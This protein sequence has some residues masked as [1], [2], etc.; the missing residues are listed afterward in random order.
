MRREQTIMNQSQI[1]P[2]ALRTGAFAL[3]S[4]LLLGLAVPALAHAET[5]EPNAVAHETVAAEPA[6]EPAPEAAPG[7]V[8]DTEPGTEPEAAPDPGQPLATEQAPQVA[9]L[10][11]APANA[12]AESG[13]EEADAIEPEDEKG[14]AA[15]PAPSSA[16]AAA[17]APG[18]ADF[19][20]TGIGPGQM[21]YYSDSVA[22]ALRYMASVAGPAGIEYQLQA[23]GHSTTDWATP[24]TRADL[25]FGSAGFTGT[26]R[27]VIRNVG[28][29]TADVFIDRGWDGLE[30]KQLRAY[31][32][33]NRSDLR[34]TG[35]VMPLSPG[36]TVEV[37]G[38]I[39]GASGAN[40]NFTVTTDAQ[41]RYEHTARGLAPGAYTVNVT[42]R[43]DGEV[44]RTI[45]GGR[46]I[47]AADAPQ[48]GLLI[49]PETGQVNGYYPRAVGVR[50][51]VVDDD[52]IEWIRATTNGPAYQTVQNGAL[53]PFATDGAHTLTVWAR[54]TLGNESNP[55]TLEFRIDSTDPTV[56][57][58]GVLAAGVVERG[59]QAVAEFTCDDATSGI[60][61]CLI[62]F[63]GGQ[64]QATGAV[65]D[66]S[67]V[68]N[69]S[70]AI[71]ARDLAGREHRSE[72]ALMVR[73]DVRPPTVTHTATPEPNARGWNREEVEVMLDARDEE[74]GL[75]SFVYRVNGGAWIEPPVLG[76][77]VRV[78]V[79]GDGR[80]TVQ[81]VAT[82]AMGNATPLTGRSVHIDA[83][84]P[85]VEIDP[86]L[87][88]RQIRQ[89]AAVLA[90]F[91]CSD[92]LSGLDGCV[93]STPNGQ[94]LPTGQ[95]G[96]HALTVTATDIAGN[97]ITRRVDYQVVADDGTALDAEATPDRAGN[98]GWWNGPVSVLLNP[99]P[100]T[101]AV[102]VAWTMIGAQTGSGVTD[103]GEDVTVTVAGLTIISYSP[104]DDY[105]RRGDARTIE[106]RIDQTTPAASAI[107]DP[108]PNARGWLRRDATLLIES[109]DRESGLD[110]LEYRLGDG[111]WVSLSS[112]PAQVPLT[113]EGVYAIE[114]RAFDVAGN[115][116]SVRSHAV[117]TDKTAPTVTVDPSIA[118]VEVEVGEAL[119]ASYA[120][121][122][123][124]SGVQACVGSI[125]LGAPLPTDAE[126][127]FELVVTALDNAGN[128]T[129][130]T[131]EYTVSAA[132]Q[133]G[134]GG[135]GNQPDPEPAQNSG[136]PGGLP[137][138]GVVEIAPLTAMAGAIAAAGL[139]ALLGAGA[140]R[141][142]STD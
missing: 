65:I 118:G 21:R 51:D 69:L 142:R 37:G 107:S 88:D 119:T 89:G 27:L 76:E 72:G 71:T 125:P 128:I 22:N 13:A 106:I 85:S 32:T 84:P 17:E 53:L 18:A 23:N 43:V 25:W 24:G 92:A 31:A 113:A 16:R 19:T 103:G 82:D 5:P 30:G 117:R 140:R 8:P 109:S 50:I 79:A 95:L 77:P 47:P 129:R 14:E 83:T 111:A 56:S 42:I 127:V 96:S 6:A 62:A 86:S 130:E 54:D 70:Y 133:G 136:S 138:T 58:S 94:P 41:G 124:L 46:V 115:A 122:D 15:D 102:G 120:C 98:R 101:G 66:T 123:A 4:T 64:P 104:V 26:V 99:D 114:Y 126:G 90:A 35:D 93:G 135:P 52:G 73:G 121:A 97:T 11:H 33:V 57:T 48:V 2:W 110:R 67:T 61:S 59:A 105:G 34:I 39:T 100:A 81:W 134:A 60:E 137:V 68:G 49:E 139:A 1:R 12:P 131:V 20:A 40:R 36:Q 78:L 74:S 55:R 28:T 44:S 7:P 38:T 63:D 75:D 87:S 80:H 132:G 45:V 29:E 112:A 91:E 3:G 9:Q 141:R 10:T 108:V 116:T